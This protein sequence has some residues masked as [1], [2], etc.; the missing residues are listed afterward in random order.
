MNTSPC[1]WAKEISDLVIYCENYAPSFRQIIVGAS[2][3]DIAS[4]EDAVGLPLPPEYRA[5][6]L[7]MGRTPQGVLGKF[8]EYITFGIDAIERFY[9]DLGRPPLPADAAYIWTYKCDNAYDIFIS[10]IGVEGNE[11]PLLQFCWPFDPDTDEYLRELPIVT[12]VAKSLLSYLYEEAFSKIRVPILPYYC[13]LRE[14]ASADKRDERYREQRRTMFQK[15]AEMLEFSAVP[16]VG[17]ELLLYDRS[18][19]ALALFSAEIAEDIVY[20]NADAER[21]LG[22]LCEIFIDNLDFRRIG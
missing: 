11:R 16:H 13:E 18:D 8:L 1:N 10:T 12:L 21:E 7:T 14:K 2:E 5:F 3:P 19:A 4:V 22:R 6:L 20:I 9:E 17:G 15:M